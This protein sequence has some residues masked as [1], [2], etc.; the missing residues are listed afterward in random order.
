MQIVFTLIFSWDNKSL[1]IP[2]FPLST[3]VNNGVLWIINGWISLKFY[4]SN[5]IKIR[6]FKILFEIKTF[7]FY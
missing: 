1:M 2:I 4:I 3:A 6:S 7:E 5:F